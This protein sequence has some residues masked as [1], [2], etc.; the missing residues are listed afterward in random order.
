MFYENLLQICKAKNVSV[1]SLVEELGLSSGNLSKWKN[2][3]KPRSDT[4]V[5]IA[6]KLDVSVNYL[7]NEDSADPKSLFYARY[8]ALSPE[9]QKVIDDMMTALEK[10]QSD[11]E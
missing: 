1:T 11:Q 3:G 5:K 10:N 7:L 8:T 6:E 4:L 2:G 9:Q